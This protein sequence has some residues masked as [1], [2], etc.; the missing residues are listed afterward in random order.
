MSL[1]IVKLEL[2]ALKAKHPQFFEKLSA[3]ESI[4][5]DIIKTAYRFDMPQEN[6]LQL[7][8]RAIDDALGVCEQQNAETVLKT[9]L[10]EIKETIISMHKD[11]EGKRQHPSLSPYPSDLPS[12][13][14]FIPHKQG[15]NGQTTDGDCQGYAEYWIY[16]M[17]NELPYYGFNLHKE[18][19]SPNIH[20]RNRQYMY[21][22]H[23][24]IL[25][26]KTHNMRNRV[27]LLHNFYPDIENFFPLSSL[28]CWPVLSENT[29]VGPGRI[30]G[31]GWA[32]G[33]GPPLPRCF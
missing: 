29:R 10:T 15:Y 5:D 4:V 11:E 23:A 12:N 1:H 13:S 24:N 30:S 33:R 14:F 19:A 9:Y 31:A 17:L 27:S 25:H 21:V 6:R 22:T 7:L 2:V 32:K 20:H 8:L 18:I 28:P 26:Q 3:I 16:C